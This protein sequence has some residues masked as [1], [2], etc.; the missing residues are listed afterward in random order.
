M[1]ERLE[2]AW[3][4]Q[5]AAREGRGGEPADRLVARAL[6]QPLPLA[7]PAGFAADVAQRALQRAAPA[8]ARVEWA[9]HALATALV[10]L[11]ALLALRLNPEL[12]S[13]WV[14]ALPLQGL[15][16]WV[17]WLG[18]AGLVTAA[19]PRRNLLRRSA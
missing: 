3:Q 2:A 7:L 12:L 8:S 17:L 6:A 19:A 18:L 1:H 14:N 16:G 15:G 4:S 10:L 9:L 11:A 5:E 13:T